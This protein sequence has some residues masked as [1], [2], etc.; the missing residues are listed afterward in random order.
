MIADSERGTV[1]YRF[2]VRG[3]PAP[4]G[5]KSFKGMSKKGHAIMVE[6]SKAVKPWREAV[7]YAALEAKGFALPLD[8]ALS[9]RMVFTMPKP[10]SAPKSRKTWANK[11]PDLSKLIRSTE[12][13]LVTSGI[14]HDDARITEYNRAAKVFAGEDTEALDSPGVV[15]TIRALGKLGPQFLKLGKE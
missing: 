14:I 6:S 5:S 7:H 2:T 4:Q 12:D 3:N 15:I 9:V 8:G 1:V 10:A 11:T 13:A